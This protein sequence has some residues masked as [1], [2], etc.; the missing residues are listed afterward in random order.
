MDRGWPRR[1]VRH[2]S[3][4]L[5]DEYEDI[6]ENLDVDDPDQALDMFPGT[7]RQGRRNNSHI[8]SSITKNRTG[9]VPPRTLVPLEDPTEGEEVS[10]WYLPMSALVNIFKFLTRDDLDRCQLVNRTWRSIVQHHPKMM[11]KREFRTL[12]LSTLNEFSMLF[13]YDCSRRKISVKKFF[14]TL[15]ID[16]LAKEKI[17]KF[18]GPKFYHNRC[19]HS[20]HRDG[21]VNNEQ[22]VTYGRIC[23]PCT[24]PLIYDE[25]IRYAKK[26]FTPPLEYFDWLTH[27]MKNGQI[28]DL[29]LKNFT[30]TDFFIEQ[31]ENSFGDY[32]AVDS[33]VLHNVSLKHVT[34]KM[35]YK[36]CGELII[37]SEYYL[38]GLRNALPHH[39]SKD[40]LLTTGILNCETLMIDKVSGRHPPRLRPLDNFTTHLDGDA[41]AEYVKERRETDNEVGLNFYVSCNIRDSRS[42]VADYKLMYMRSS[43]AERKGMFKHFQVEGNAW[44]ADVELS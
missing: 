14:T 11:A 39:I 40:L 44:T 37:A 25:R 20:Y 21:T 26:L 43:Y 1:R 24:A 12:E 16:S 19:E 28:K 2:R 30:L 38:E 41:I 17:E 5:D 15:D 23:Q 27:Y 33:L 3:D 10:A 18:R 35:F 32:M 8:I 36:F 6:S 22:F 4:R 7:S 42:I 13:Y 34:P 31:W 29:V 9:R